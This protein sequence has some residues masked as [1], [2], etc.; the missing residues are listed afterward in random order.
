MGSYRGRAH[1]V[2]GSDIML[3]QDPVERSPE[4]THQSTLNKAL[5]AV[6]KHARDGDRSRWTLKTSVLECMEFVAAGVACGEQPDRALRTFLAHDCTWLQHP[7]LKE[8]FARYVE[9][10]YIVLD[11]PV[12]AD[13]SSLYPAGAL[14]LE[15]AAVTGAVD[16][17]KALLDA[18]RG[19]VDVDSIRGWV[20]SKVSRKGLREKLI[21]LVS[22]DLEDAIHRRIEEASGGVVVNAT[23]N[24]QRRLRDI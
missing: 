24:R 6:A 7:E 15:A 17:F 19:S 10:G 18:G 22:S 5:E 16:T 21:S 3:H 8:L 20:A 14:P 13:A 11:R 12:H 4:A 9:T 2:L 1:G 23:V